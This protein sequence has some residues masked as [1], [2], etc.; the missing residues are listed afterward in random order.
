MYIRLNIPEG[1]VSFEKLEELSDVFGVRIKDS[2]EQRKTY[3]AFFYRYPVDV[4]VTL[5]HI[6]KLMNLGYELTF[7]NNVLGIK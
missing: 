3:D 1:L 2:F 4:E 7:K 5:E 6:Q